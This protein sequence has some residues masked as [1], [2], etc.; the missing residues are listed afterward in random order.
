M[1]DDLSLLLSNALFG[2]GAA[3]AVLWTRPRGLELV[4]SSSFHA[5]EDREAIRYVHKHGQLY[6]QLSRTC[7]PSSTRRWP[8]PS[9]TSWNPGA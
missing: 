2:D 9:N 6:N 1:E 7:R 8:R 5:P 3:A 4:A